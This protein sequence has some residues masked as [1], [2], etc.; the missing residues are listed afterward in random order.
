M[1]HENLNSRPMIYMAGPLFNEA[2]RS[3]NVY[4]RHLLEEFYDVYLPQEDGL[5]IPDLIKSGMSAERASSAIFKNDLNAIHRCDLLLILLDGRTVDEGAAMELGYAYCLGKLCVS[6]QTD[7][8]RLS[9]FGNNPMITGAVS[10]SFTRV[11]DLISWVK[12]HTQT[13]FFMRARKQHQL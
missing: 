13:N 2:E 3:Y 4:I 8:R 12:E 1:K 7:F 5:L 9:P 6:L 10:H 11:E